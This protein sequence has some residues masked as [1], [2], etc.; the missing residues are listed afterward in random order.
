MSESNSID[1]DKTLA[2][3]GQAIPVKTDRSVARIVDGE[4]VVVEPG[5]G[6]VNIINEA[7]T[8]IWELADGKLTAGDIAGLIAG[9]FDVSRDRALAD[10]IEFLRDLK[11]KGL[12]TVKVQPRL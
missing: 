10:T 1:P 3:A 4:A 7:G 8:R 5:N 2:C 11:E 6:L 9:E 12:V